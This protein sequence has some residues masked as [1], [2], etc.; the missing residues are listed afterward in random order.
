[1]DIMLDALNQHGTMCQISCPCGLPN[2]LLAMERNLQ[3]GISGL[4]GA[5]EGLFLEPEEKEVPKGTR[6]CLYMDKLVNL[7]SPSSS[8]DYSISVAVNAVTGIADAEECHNIFYGPKCNNK[9][10]V[11]RILSIDYNVP[12]GCSTARGI[13]TLNPTTLESMYSQRKEY[14]ASS[15]NCKFSRRNATTGIMRQDNFERKQSFTCNFNDRK[16]KFRKIR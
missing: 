16:C 7:E 11:D 2:E 14:Q 5:G 6:L 10:F 15:S 12:Q 1:M 4:E 9:S 3:V 13:S 8:D